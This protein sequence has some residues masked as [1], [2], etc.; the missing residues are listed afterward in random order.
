MNLDLLL[1]MGYALGIGV[2]IGLERSMGQEPRPASPAPA[3]TTPAPA[4]EPAPADDDA[5]GVRTFAVLSLAGFG[6]ALAGER[7]PLLPP[8]ALAGVCALVIALYVRG[9][10]LG[11]GITTEAAAI[12]TCLL[13]FLTRSHAHAAG[14]LALLLT[15]LLASKRFT[16]QTV[17]RMRRVELTDTLKLLVVVLIV[18]P[19]LPQKAVD[20]WGALVPR[21]VG[22]LVVLISGIGFVGYFLT[23]ILGA[24][25]GL[26]LTGVL[27]GLTSSTAVTAAMAAEAKQHPALAAIC[28]FSTVAANATMFGRVLAVV[29]VLDSAL[30]LR[31]AW[32]IGA[33]CLVAAAASVVLWLRAGRGER[34]TEQS[35]IPLKNPFSV[36]PALKFAAFF[37]AILFVAKLAKTYLG[38]RGLFAAAA[39]SGLADVDAI[40]L[41][42]AEQT[43]AAALAHGAGALGITIAIVSNSVVKTGIACYSGGWAFGRLI[44][45][46]L[47]LA[48]G[49]GLAVAFLK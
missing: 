17:R 24:R 8:V 23:R 37:V 44:A 19:L 32:P 30:A 31:L 48:T 42:I 36:G 4:V 45:I 39:L 2:L 11:L 26:G 38:D 35:E 18:L 13:G 10:E 25:R 47:G 34:P 20:P 7:F 14:V 41:T 43:K 12:T 27:G 40:T 49:A 22:I 1:E 15:V 33:M 28:S 9:R 5:M 3:P 21:K 16:H 6:A 29:G 46:C